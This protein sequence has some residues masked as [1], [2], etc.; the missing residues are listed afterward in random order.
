MEGYWYE[1]DDCTDDPESAIEQLAPILPSLLERERDALRLVKELASRLEEI[2]LIYTISETLGRTVRLRDAAQKILEEVS[3]V[4]GA[5]RGSILVH[6]ESRMMLRA[7]AWIGKDVGQFKPI[8][9]DD[10]CS[11]AASVFREVVTIS[12][13]PRDTSAVSPG[14]PNGRDYRGTAFL[15]VPIVYTVPDGVRR[16]VGVINLT[17]RAGTDAFSGGERRLVEAIASQIAV[18][19]E[20]ARLVARD[21]EQERLRQE[22]QLAHDLQLKLLPSPTVLGPLVDVAANCEPAQS[23]GGDFYNLL[24]L[25]EGRIGVMLGDVSSHGFSSALIMALV[26]SASGIHAGEAE[27]PDDALRTLLGSIE[28]EL[29][30]TEMHLALFYGV[31]DPRRGALK[32]ANAGHPHAFRVT[33]SGE[34]ERLA[35]TCPPLGLAGA[36]GI[37][38]AE[39]QWQT[40]SDLLVLF[41]DGITEATD[42]SGE[43]FGEDRLLDVVA[44]SHAESAQ[45]IVDSVV[46]AVADFAAPATDD[47]TILV[48][49][50]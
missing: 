2:E 24:R 47:R 3:Q 44:G 35:A 26:L 12:H 23:V 41:T 48:L 28:K 5:Q 36:S 16:P 15:S 31:V 49:R 21:V 43:M 38:A 45:S 6:D 27:S 10:E 39:T 37:S 29:A 1:V 50:A 46:H 25:Q 4:V 14:C 42:E 30:E 34:R 9:V 11:I 19:I 8:S 18:A 33:R 17:D 32:F 13:D 40:D 7:A 20:N 22:L